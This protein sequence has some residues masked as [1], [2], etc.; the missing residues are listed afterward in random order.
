MGEESGKEGED[1]LRLISL[2][3]GRTWQR[4]ER[5][6]SRLLANELTPQLGY[7][8]HIGRSG[9]ILSVVDEESRTHHAGSTRKPLV[10]EAMPP[11]GEEGPTSRQLTAPDK[12]W[13]RNFNAR[14]IGI[15]L[16]GHGLNELHHF[17]EEQVFY[18]NCLIANLQRRFGFA[19]H[20]ILG[21]DEASTMHLIRSTNKKLG[22]KEG[23]KEQIDNWYVDLEEVNA[24]VAAFNADVET[25]NDEAKAFNKGRKKKRRRLKK[26]LK[27]V[28]PRKQDP[29]EALEMGMPALRWIHG[30]REASE[31]E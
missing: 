30:G 18:C 21:H 10:L 26:E 23:D 17:N 7:Q 25:Y 13:P 22:A 9:M 3:R 6:K 1:S 20:D 24:Q 11:G 5:K 2:A 12:R 16:I 28:K 8:F 15:D 29:G 14:A 31:E 4:A 19:W 27:P